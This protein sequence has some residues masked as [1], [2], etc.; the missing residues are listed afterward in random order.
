MCFGVGVGD[1]NVALPAEYASSSEIGSTWAGEN[2]LHYVTLGPTALAK[3]NITAFKTALAKRGAPAQPKPEFAGGRR[4][5]YNE[6]PIA[7]V[8][9]TRPVVTHS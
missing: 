6:V 9:D 3:S 2:G 7:H 1:E 5:L 4:Y 8:S